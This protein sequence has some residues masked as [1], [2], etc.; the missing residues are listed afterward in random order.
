MRCV[1][2]SGLLIHSNKKLPGTEECSE[3]AEKGMNVSVV[4]FSVVSVSSVPVICTQGRKDLPAILYNEWA[5]MQCS[6]KTVNKHAHE[7]E[8]RLSVTAEWR[9]QIYVSDL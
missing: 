1:S 7:Y 5:C 6:T 4:A 8:N 2:I 9:K 3:T